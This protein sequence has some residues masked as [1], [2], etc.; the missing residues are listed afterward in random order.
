MSVF[1]GKNAAKMFKKR[2]IINNQHIMNNLGGF[3][4]VE[5]LLVDEVHV[6]ARNGNRVKIERDGEFT[7]HLPLHDESPSLSASPQK[8]EAGTI[9]EHKCTI[10]LR[11]RVMSH[12]LIE[13]LEQA[14]IRGCILIAT[15]N[16]NELRV[17]GSK[18]Y[19]LHGS[20]TENY[21]SRRSDLHRH[22]LY[23]TSHNLHPELA[24]Q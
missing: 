23:L 4:R 13:L 6:F 2:V 18:Q 9:F 19:P 1:R 10:Y 20:L 17:F 21:G 8:D 16:N 15:T 7:R 11:S 24:L 5:L 3:K 12:Q 22:E 14:C